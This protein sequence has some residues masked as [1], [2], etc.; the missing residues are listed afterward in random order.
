MLTLQSSAKCPFGEIRFSEM[1]FGEMDDS[2]NGFDKM[3]FWQNI[4]SVK[5]HLI[6]TSL[7]QN[8]FGEMSFDERIS[9]KYTVTIK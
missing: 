4:L 9:A 2:V 7:R 1:E 6:E 3:H 8:G 5:H